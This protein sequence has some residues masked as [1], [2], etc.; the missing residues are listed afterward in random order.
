MLSEQSKHALKG[1]LLAVNALRAA[2]DKPL[3]STVETHW[4][5]VGFRDYMAKYQSIVN[6]VSQIVQITVPITQWDLSKIKG[7]MDTIGLLQ[8]EAF[9]AVYTNLSLLGSFI[10]HT[11]GVRD[12]E[13][14]SLSDFFQANL[15]KAVF[16]EPS[17]EKNIQDVIEQLLIGRGLSRGID[18]EREKG[19]VKVS[20]KETIP[21]F[22]VSRLSLAIEIKL[23]RDKA[24]ARTI[25]DEINADIQ[26][27]G[28]AY[29]AIIFVVYD[30]GSIQDADEYRQGISSVEKNIHVV[31][32]KH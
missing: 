32:V 7:S 24:A 9:E 25:V 28:K 18:Y 30:L 3:M 22:I 31:V 17:R 23:S 2:M 6:Q 27:Y 8:K 21:D 11:L 1:H 19:R 12:D 16:D 4:R 15:R 14:R 10:E 29:A 20:I 26:A 5:Y 13:I